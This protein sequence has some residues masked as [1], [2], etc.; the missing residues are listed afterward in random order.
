[1]KA[2]I[3]EPAHWFDQWELLREGGLVVAHGLKYLQ[4]TYSLDT[5]RPTEVNCRE[6]WEEKCLLWKHAHIIADETLGS[7]EQGA[8]EAEVKDKA[9]KAVGVG[10]GWG[11]RGMST[12]N[13]EVWREN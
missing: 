7:G 13:S 9:G 8:K 3:V 5:T 6:K 10:V 4:N 11:G 2:K 1:M 12:G